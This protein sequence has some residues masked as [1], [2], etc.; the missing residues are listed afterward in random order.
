M[1]GTWTVPVDCIARDGLASDAL[2]GAQLDTGLPA[3]GATVVGW[4]ASAVVGLGF[5]RK[6]AKNA[7]ARPATASPPR[8]NGDMGH[9]VREAAGR[10]HALEGVRVYAGC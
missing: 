2:P 4:A 1:S 7:P 9:L 10:P 6:P 5:T 8:S 3:V